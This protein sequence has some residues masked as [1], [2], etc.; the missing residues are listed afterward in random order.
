MT[1]SLR[2][3]RASGAYE[4]TGI[5]PVKQRLMRSDG[6]LP[7]LEVGAGKAALTAVGLGQMVFVAKLAKLG[8]NNTNLTIVG[9][10]ACWIAY[11]ALKTP[12]TFPKFI[13]ASEHESIR[14]KLLSLKPEQEAKRFVLLPPDATWKTVIFTDDPAADLKKVEGSAITI[15]LR[16]LGEDLAGRAGALVE[17]SDS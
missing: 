17:F 8:I 7:K 2:I 11:W 9:N 3:F 14:R 6:Q 10:A 15:D 5:E 4:I 12:G 1:L 13:P 16:M